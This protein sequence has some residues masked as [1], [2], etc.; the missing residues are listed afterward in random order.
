MASSGGGSG[1]GR[2]PGSGS[3]GGVESLLATRQRLLAVL[4]E[5]GGEGLSVRYW[6]LLRAFLNG[7]LTK[8]ELDRGIYECL[9]DKR[10]TEFPQSRS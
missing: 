2:G 7:K 10:R 3:S 5:R 6:E 4:A 9:G 8:Y 1:C